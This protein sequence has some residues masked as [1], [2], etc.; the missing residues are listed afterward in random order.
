MKI[1]NV[2][3]LGRQDIHS[4]WDDH[5]SI[6]F[7]MASNQIVLTAVGRDT[8]QLNYIDLLIAREPYPFIFEKELPEEVIIY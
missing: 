7:L 2:S 1:S 3:K 6:F 8:L 4:F 5:S